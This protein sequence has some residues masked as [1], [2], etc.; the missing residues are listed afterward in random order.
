MNIIKTAPH[1]ILFLI[2]FFI[3][4]K[5]NLWIFG[6]WFG[7][8]YTDNSKYLFEY[9]LKN[10]H[11]INAVWITAN[12][13]LYNELQ[14]NNI[15]VCYK[16]SFKGIWYVLRAKVVIFVQ[17]CNADIM[18][19][20]NW[21]RTKYIQL[22]HGIPL[23]KIKYDDDLIVKNLKLLKIKLLIKKYLYPVLYEKFTFMTAC[24]NED[25]GHFSS[26]FLIYNEKIKI[27]GYPRNDALFS[28][29]QKNNDK[30]KIIYMPTFRGDKGSSFDFF[31]PYGFN[32]NFIEKKL[33]DINGELYLK[34]HPVNKPTEKIINDIKQSKNIFFYDDSKDIYDELSTYNILITDFSSVYFDYLLTNQPI[35]AASFDFDLYVNKD[36]QLYYDYNKIMPAPMCNNWNEVITWIEKFND[37]SSLYAEKRKKIKNKFHKYQDGNSCKRVY[38]EILRLLDK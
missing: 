36:R 33:T 17:S 26:A 34:L 27:T 9:I 2:S 30:Y 4:K 14:V 15:K 13:K 16:Y 38:Y 7:E 11:E 35:I 6:S 23:K 37:D 10:H 28:P 31:T 21:Y 1:L 5:R 22:W 25:R 32:I 20:I 12:K 8:K 24:S 18:H 29:I 3:P 19:G